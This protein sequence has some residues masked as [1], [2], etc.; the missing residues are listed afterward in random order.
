MRTLV[1]R[2]F[3]KNFWQYYIDLEKQF[4]DTQRYVAFDAKNNATFSMEYI[5]LLQVICS[6][7]D[8]VGKVIGQHFNSAFVVDNNTNINKWG[9]QVQTAFPTIQSKR[10][11]FWNE[12]ELMPWAK[13]VY[14]VSANGYPILDKTVNAKTPFWWNAYNGVKHQ[15]TSIGLG[16]R[17]NYMR[18]N[19]KTVTNALSALYIMEQMMLDSYNPTEVAGIERSRAFRIK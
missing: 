2:E 4:I 11:I 14:V 17:P 1:A 13:W 6:E 3:I 5:M 8:V 7:I 10:V 15:R 18:A 16:Q 12:F 19:L 9:Y